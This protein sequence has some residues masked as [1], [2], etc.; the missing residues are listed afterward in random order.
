MLKRLP[1]ECYP[2]PQHS[3]M[4]LSHLSTGIVLD[5]THTTYVWCV[6]KMS[7]EVQKFQDFSRVVSKR[8]R[9]TSKMVNGPQTR[10]FCQALPT[11]PNWGR[12]F[13]HPI[14]TRT[15]NFGAAILLA[16]KIN[17]RVVITMKLVN[18]AKCTTYYF[19]SMHRCRRHGYAL[20]FGYL[21][22]LLRGVISQ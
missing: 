14:Y 9:I 20:R 1:N 3:P 6:G 12:I 18:S 22:D 16:D 8:C 10:T 7:Y 15:E 5:C 21:H 4:H 11:S 19:A 13:Q 17:L 2:L